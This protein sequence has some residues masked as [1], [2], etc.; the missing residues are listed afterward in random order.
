MEGRDFCFVMDNHSFSIDNS[1]KISVFYPRLIPVLWCDA[2]F[3]LL[4]VGR[5][6]E[7]LTETLRRGVSLC[8][9]ITATDPV[10]IIGNQTLDVLGGVHQ[11]YRVEHF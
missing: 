10:G 8:P 9:V 11:V 5:V 6:E 2:C 1:Q 4:G 7:A 3:M